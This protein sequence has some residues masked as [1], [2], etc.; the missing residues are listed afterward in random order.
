MSVNLAPFNVAL[1]SSYATPN[2]AENVLN[3]KFFA[4]SPNEKWVTNITYIWCK[5]Q[6][7]YFMAVMD[8]F[9]R[10]IVSGSF[11]TQMT[12]LLIISA[13]KMAIERREI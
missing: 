7:L 12:E 13:L 3:R 10:A 5:G 1:Q 4:A 2:E 8:L 6:W 11:Y 9:P